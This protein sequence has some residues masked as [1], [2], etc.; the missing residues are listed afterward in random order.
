MTLSTLLE[1]TGVTDIQY[2]DTISSTNDVAMQWIETGAPDLSIVV[3]DQQTHGRGRLDRKWITNPGCALA[4]SLILTPS[5][6]EKANIA[7]FSPLVALALAL[8]LE[9]KY[10]LKPQIKWPND[11]LINKKKISGIL[12]EANWTGLA[13]AGVVI[14]IGI[15]IAPSSIPP[16]EQLLFP[17][18]CVEAEIGSPVDRFDLLRTYLNSFRNLRSSLGT[19]KFFQQW[20][21]RLAF[22]NK[23]V[24]IEAT[25]RGTIF[26]VLK[27]ITKTGNL[28]LQKNTGELVEIEIG[29]VHLRPD[30]KNYNQ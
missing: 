15:N 23:Q 9:E 10:G 18:T 17:A 26:G 16:P 11:I 21:Q 3:A 24:R 27:G 19:E 5:K 12:V 7:L 1:N 14:G 6:A 28:L 30:F 4:F 8:T 29:D 22:R 20:E 25:G 13:I 2:F